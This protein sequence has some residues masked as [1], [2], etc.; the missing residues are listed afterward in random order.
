MGNDGPMTIN[1]RRAGSCLGALTLGVLN[2]PLAAQNSKDSGTDS[3][4][5]SIEA[6]RQVE[7]TAEQARRDWAV[8]QR[9][10][11]LPFTLRWVG[12]RAL[13]LF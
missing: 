4:T 12:A 7:L 13:V 8:F 5:D 10:D 11:K 3:R 1:R 9:A 6:A 2:M